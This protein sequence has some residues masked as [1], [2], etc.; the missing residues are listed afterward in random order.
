MKLHRLLGT[1][2]LLAVALSL[3]VGAAEIT[4]DRLINA[5]KDANNWLMVHRTYD[6]HR[7]SPNDQIT[8]DNV[9][10][11][12]VA[13]FLQFDV[14]TGLGRYPNARNE[15]TPLVEDGFMYVQ[16]GWSKIYKVDVRDG[17]WGKIV[18]KIDPQVDRQWIV[19]ATC[20]GN[21]NR[22]TALWG[23]DLIAL[24]LDGRVMSIN[25]NTGEVNWEKQRASKDRAESFTVAPLV[26]NDTAVYGP[27]GGEYG[28]RGWVEAINL[29]NGELAW[30]HYNIPAPGEPG[31]ETWKAARTWETGGA[32][33][34]QTGSY[35]PETNLTYWGTGNPAPQIDA[36]YRPGDNLYASSLLALDAGTGKM[37]WY[38]QFTPNDP[39]DYDE[40][41]EAQIVSTTI[42]G[43]PQKLVIRAARNGFMYGFNNANGQFI[44][45]KQYVTDLNWTTGLDPKTGRPLNYDPAGGLQKYAPGTVGSRDKEAGI[46]CPTLSG[47]KNWQPGSL[48]A[49]TGYLYITSSE[50]CSAYIPTAAPNPTITGGTYNVAT[51]GREWNGRNPAPADTKLPQTFNGASVVAIDPK[52][53]NNVAKSLLPYRGNGMLATAGGLVFTSDRGGMLYAYDDRDLKLVW[54]Q[55]MGT[56]L[57]SPPISYMVNGKQY[58]AVETGAAPAPQHIALDPALKYFSSIDGMFVLSLN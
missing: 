5:D 40:I 56:S 16:P 4:K 19:D 53:G 23:N 3:P 46:Y 50:G 14:T 26:I 39:Y 28:I 42:N 55:N 12:R 45:G 13:F 20:C 7:Y 43:Q 24:T 58:I 31:N 6:A 15:N 1:T 22:G 44:Y 2:S 57:A 49:K 9:Q 33:I 34:W 25:K 51:A 48:S 52:T 37:A 41:G 10:N 8:R 54:S 35:D 27:A 11:L 21:E 32:S 30:R 47:G 36:E 18:W 38:F 29:K 17:R